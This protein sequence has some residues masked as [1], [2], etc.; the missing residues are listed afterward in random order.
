LVTDQVEEAKACISG[1]E[2][3]ESS[4]GCIIKGIITLEVNNNNSNNN[5]NDSNNNMFKL[6]FSGKAL[7]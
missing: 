1:E 2:T 7:F 3:S 6:F 5:H 4:C